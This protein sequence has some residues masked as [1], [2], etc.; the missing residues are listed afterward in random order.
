[1]L[2]GSAMKYFNDNVY[3][4]LGVRMGDY[5]KWGTDTGLAKLYDA[6]RQ[7]PDLVIRASGPLI[8]QIM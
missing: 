8:T 3:T 7:N 1:M 5:H 6:I 4:N 2:N